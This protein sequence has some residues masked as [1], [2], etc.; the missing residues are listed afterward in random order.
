MW[1]L[2]RFRVTQKALQYCSCLSHFTHLWSKT[3]VTQFGQTGKM[4]C[5]KYLFQS[6]ISCVKVYH[7]MC[8]RENNNGGSKRAW[9]FVKVDILQPSFLCDFFC[10]SKYNPLFWPDPYF[11]VLDILW[12][13]FLRVFF[14]FFSFFVISTLL[15]FC[16]IF[17]TVI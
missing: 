13:S 16:S 3:N 14:F 4:L 2:F 9:I 1:E 8:F 12:P 15:L 11:T 5:E 17:L 6:E 7:A 10:R